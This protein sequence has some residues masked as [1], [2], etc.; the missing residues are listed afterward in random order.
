M[1][2]IT[3]EQKVQNLKKRI[4]ELRE[5]PEMPA[6]GPYAEWK[7]KE[8]VWMSKKAE[9]I[10]DIH[11]LLK[12]LVVSKEVQLLLDDLQEISIKHKEAIKGKCS[13]LKIFSG[14]NNASNK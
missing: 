9:V 11:K 8:A 13:Q 6:Q 10:F 5:F 7:K 1:S 4:F 12:C 2:E 3:D 14:I